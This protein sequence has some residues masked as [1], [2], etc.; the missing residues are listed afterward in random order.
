[1]ATATESTDNSMERT[2]A[3]CGRVLTIGEGPPRSRRGDRR[4]LLD[5]AEAGRSPMRSAMV[6]RLSP[7]VAV[8][9]DRET[10]PWR[11]RLSTTAA[12]L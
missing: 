8:S 10:G 2:T 1:M 3:P 7:V 4:A 9:S 12:R 5:E 6:D 11:W